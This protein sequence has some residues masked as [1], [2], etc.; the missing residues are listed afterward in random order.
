M[1]ITRGSGECVSGETRFCWSVIFQCCEQHKPKCI[2]LFPGTDLTTLTDK[3]KIVCMNKWGKKGHNWHLMSKTQICTG[4]NLI[5]WALKCETAWSYPWFSVIL[6]VMFAWVSS[7]L[8]GK[9]EAPELVSVPAV[10][11]LHA[12]FIW[13][14]F[15]WHREV[16]E[17]RGLDELR[18]RS[19]REIQS[20]KCHHTRTFL[21]SGWTRRRAIMWT[22]TLHQFSKEAFNIPPAWSEVI[23]HRSTSQEVHAAVMDVGELPQDRRIVFEVPDVSA[24]L[25][26][27]WV[28]VW[29]PPASGDVSRYSVTFQSS[30]TAVREQLHLFKGDGTACHF[31]LLFIF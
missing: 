20:D 18:V 14:R 29:F 25:L 1:W 4:W 16:P 23:G 12:V 27:F 26:C 15:Q 11:Q 7:V 17:E 8:R 21:C 22:W 6:N 30:R 5:K 13:G 19:S 24:G 2:N 28:T 31:T 9:R 3:T 10:P